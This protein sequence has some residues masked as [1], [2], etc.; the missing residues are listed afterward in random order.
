[1]IDIRY[2]KGQKLKKRRVRASGTASRASRWCIATDGVHI[3][4]DADASTGIASFDFDH[5][6]ARRAPRPAGAG[7][8]AALRRAARRQ[9]ADHRA[10]RRMG[11]GARAGLRQPRY[12]RR[13]DQPHHRHHHHAR[14]ASAA[15]AS[16][17]YLRPDVHIYVEDGRSFV[18]RSH[19]E[20]PGDAG[21]AGGHLGLHRRRRVRAFR[22]QPLHHRRLPRLS[23]APD[24]R[25]HGR[26]HALGLRSAARIAAPGFAGHGGA[27]RSWAKPEP[28]RHVIVG[29]G[30]HRRRAGARRIPC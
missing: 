1:M 6:T 26:L 4:I 30:G 23:L 20:I 19:R 28:W 8:G 13:R 15:R 2:A 24:R 17:L 11:C 18:R 7:S 21:H 12:H 5:L 14:A 10:G 27:A 9:D 22:K 16:G 29:R 3:F 25:R